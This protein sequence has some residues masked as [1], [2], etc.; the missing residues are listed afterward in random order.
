MS[1]PRL[2]RRAELLCDSCGIESQ[3]LDRFQEC[4]SCSIDRMEKLH[5]QVFHDYHAGIAPV[6]CYQ[7]YKRRLRGFKAN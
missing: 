1:F 6:Y 5:E 7:D 2:Y 4:E 3:D